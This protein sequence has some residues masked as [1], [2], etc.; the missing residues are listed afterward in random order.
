MGQLLSKNIPQDGAALAPSTASSTAPSTA[1]KPSAPELPK[2]KSEKLSTPEWIAKKRRY[3]P[4]KVRERKRQKLAHR[5]SQMLDLFTRFLFHRYV[6]D[7]EA[8][9]IKFLETEELQEDDALLDSLSANLELKQEVKKRYA[10]FRDARQ[11]LEIFMALNKAND[12]EQD[13]DPEV[14]QENTL[15]FWK[16]A[17]SYVV[18]KEYKEL[19]QFLE[20]LIIKLNFIDNPKST[21][22]TCLRLLDVAQLYFIMQSYKSDVDAA[23][24]NLFKTT[25]HKTLESKLLFI[26]NLIYE[27]KACDEVF[28]AVDAFQCYYTGMQMF[29][30]FYKD[31][32]EK[33][34]G[35]TA[36]EL[37][38][39]I[40]RRMDIVF[41]KSKWH[42][43][44]IMFKT[45][46]ALRFYEHIFTV[47]DVE[48][49]RDI[50]VLKF[51]MDP[52]RKFYDSIKLLC[53]DETI[54]VWYTEQ[55]Q[56][57][58]YVHTTFK[59]EMEG[60]IFHK[61]ENI[62]NLFMLVHEMDCVEI[63]FRAELL[64]LIFSRVQKTFSSQM[65]ETFC[66]DYLKRSPNSWQECELM[67]LV[68]KSLSRTG[69]KCRDAAIKMLDI[70]VEPDPIYVKKQKHRVVG[71]KT[72][73]Q[74]LEDSV[75]SLQETV[76]KASMCPILHK[77]MVDPVTLDCG[78][79]FE[80]HSICT[81]LEKN[82]KCPLCQKNHFYKHGYKNQ[83]LRALGLPVLEKKRQVFREIRAMMEVSM[84]EPRDLMEVFVI[85]LSEES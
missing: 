60:V 4:R 25:M 40:K 3:V 19:S 1:S 26:F 63:A 44:V 30:G 34:V 67:S 13:W 31:I 47:E 23:F 62:F 43:H 20:N 71:P 73:V 10:Q 42:C 68:V 28:L 74:H 7:M 21:W 15:L 37:L 72:Y 49:K 79:A 27:H 56:L 53:Q 83:T 65:L 9:D 80:E 81:W 8:N 29:N 5:K 85:D 50:F 2:A 16:D 11:S 38:R 14:A 55:C 76:Q 22:Y 12:V 48:M 41:T 36:R 51:M 70:E 64:E 75:R 69:L 54:L 45:R 78:H 52:S 61:K 66:F 58:D 46:V 18:K 17:L 59:K 82:S 6:Q 77:T 24:D 33:Q 39:S 35:R 57:A 32:K 84:K